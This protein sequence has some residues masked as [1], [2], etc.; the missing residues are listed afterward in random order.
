MNGLN[1]TT[2]TEIIHHDQ[3]CPSR[4][5]KGSPSDKKENDTDGKNRFYSKGYRDT[6]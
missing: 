6:D 1:Q 5:V 4:K 2:K 3:I